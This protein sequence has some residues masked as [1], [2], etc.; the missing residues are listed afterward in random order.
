[1]IPSS[2]IDKLLGWIMYALSILSLNL[3]INLS[4]DSTLYALEDFTSIGISFWDTLFPV[5][6]SIS[7]CYVLSFK[8]IFVIRCHLSITIKHYIPNHNIS[9]HPGKT[10]FYIYFP[11]KQYRYSFHH[12][13]LYNTIQFYFQISKQDWNRNLQINHTARWP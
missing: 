9:L 8:N 13:N 6:I 4:I 2:F 5:V 3:S 10:F 7:L 11:L 12:L 1:M